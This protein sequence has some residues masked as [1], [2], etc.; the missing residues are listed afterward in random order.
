M[1]RDTEHKAQNLLSD[2]RG[3]ALAL[4]A[5]TMAAMLAMGALAID[6]G[7]A[8]TA[9]AAAQRAAD[10]AALAGA[11]A[12]QDFTKAAAPGPAQDRAYEYALANDVLRRPIDSSQVE[13]WVIPDEQ[14]VRVRITEPDLPTW[15][16]R[17]I[18]WE[19][20][21][22]AAVAAAV[23]SSGGSSDQC[24]LPFAIV[25]LWDENDADEDPNN[26]DT[27][28]DGEEWFLQ[29]DE[30]GTS[31]DPYYPY[32]DEDAADEYPS[33]Y[34]ATRGT[35]LGSSFRD[36]KTPQVTYS[37][38]GDLGR[39]IVLK[40][41]P[42]EGGPASGGSPGGGWHPTPSGTTGP[43][44]FQIWQMPDIDDPNSCAAGTGQGGTSYVQSQIAGCNPCDILL[45]T[46][47]PV[48]TGMKTAIDKPLKELY[49]LDSGA[50]WSESANRIVGSRF[51]E[52]GDG[53]MSGVGDLSPL[54]R[55]AA[56]ASPL[57]DFT[58]GSEPIQFNNFAYV[59]LEPNSPKGTV[60]IRFLGPVSGGSGPSTGPL[61]KYLRLVE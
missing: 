1:I 17:L 31:P 36:G 45:G 38:P 13:V 11:S 21:Q 20:M 19:S 47:Y 53:G 60:Y 46:D 3:Q 26:N 51:G 34:K 29:D 52:L 30:E 37:L 35:G 27:P 9:R 61:V 42:G 39:R 12:F 22:V 49:A 32:A 8:F 28:D 50:E 5:V 48:T 25:D 4:A 43:G 59:F 10:A 56:I 15:F 2:R 57:Q 33:P 18:G 24:V 55:I 40:T 16:A 23:A 6:L 54:I 7:L 58:G 44:N 41:S 14:K